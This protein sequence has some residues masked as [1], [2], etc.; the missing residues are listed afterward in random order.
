MT[1][2]LCQLDMGGCSQPHCAHA[3]LKLFYHRLQTRQTPYYN[4][5]GSKDSRTNLVTHM[6]QSNGS[7]SFQPMCDRYQ[8]LSCFVILQS[9]TAKNLLTESLNKRRSLSPNCKQSFNNI[10]QLSGNSHISE[11][12]VLQFH[13]VV[14]DNNH[15]MLKIVPLKLFQIGNQFINKFPTLHGYLVAHFQPQPTRLLLVFVCSLETRKTNHYCLLT[16]QE[17][18]KTSIFLN[19]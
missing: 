17:A 4:V 12:T 16:F 3:H 7:H 9:Y 6:C 1:V 15:L 14:V 13:I 8:A 11:I 18:Q 19:H 5:K 10:Y 2:S